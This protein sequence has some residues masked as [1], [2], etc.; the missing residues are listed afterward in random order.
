[1]NHLDR[2]LD[3]L[4]HDCDISTPVW[5]AIRWAVRVIEAARKLPIEETAS[6]TVVCPGC[7]CEYCKLRRVLAEGGE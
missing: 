1:M 5:G 3:T 4:A 2:L 7:D 6:C